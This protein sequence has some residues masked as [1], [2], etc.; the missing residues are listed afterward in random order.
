MAETGLLLNLVDCCSSV[1][2]SLS[3][4][5]LSAWSHRDSEL[6][7]MS[8]ARSRP[9]AEPQGLPALVVFLLRQR[10]KGGLL[11]PRHSIDRSLLNECE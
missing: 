7:R 5:H 3:F 9:A 6:F 2:D 1:A 4:P 8:L 11:L 10:L